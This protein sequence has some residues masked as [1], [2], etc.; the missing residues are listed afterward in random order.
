MSWQQWY[1]NNQTTF[2][3]KERYNWSQYTTTAI[4][5][6]NVVIVRSY[7]KI[8]HRLVVRL[9][10]R[11]YCIIILSVTRNLRSFTRKMPMTCSSSYCLQ[12][13]AIST[14]LLV[15]FLRTRNLQK[16]ISSAVYGNAYIFIY[17]FLAL[18]KTL[19]YENLWI[20][21]FDKLIFCK[22]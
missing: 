9:R 11:Y 14:C 8:L 3:K 15:T 21:L 5:Q 6:G 18:K 2:F 1:S 13:T 17:W 4:Q 22:E 7:S 16:T 10:V 12:V 20:P 19:V